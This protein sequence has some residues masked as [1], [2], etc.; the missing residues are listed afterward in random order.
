VFQHDEEG[1]SLLVVSFCAS[2]TRRDFPLHVV[3]VFPYDKEGNIPPCHFLFCAG[4][5]VPLIEFC[6]GFPVDKEG[7]F[8]APYIFLLQ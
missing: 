3:F 8:I 2:T 5:R 1:S 7:F 6:F 4:K